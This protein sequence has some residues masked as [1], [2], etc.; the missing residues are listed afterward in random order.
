MGKEVV[1]QDASSK[2][3]EYSR[4]WNHE[5]IVD[6]LTINSGSDSIQGIMFDPPQLENV[7]WCGSSFEKMN[8]LRILIVRNADFSVAPK[9]LPNN[10]RM[11]EWNR[12]L[13]EYLPQGFYPKIMVVLKLKNSQ[14]ISSIPLQNLE[15]L[16]HMDFSNCR[17]VTQVPDLSSAPNITTLALQGCTGLINVH[18]SVGIHP[19]LRDLSFF[20]CTNLTIFPRGIKMTSLERLHLSGC[21]S[22]QH[23]PNILEE[24]VNLWFINA[25]CTSI[26]EIPHSICYLPRLKHLSLSFCYDLISLPESIS[27]LDRLASLDLVDCKKLRQFSAPPNLAKLWMDGCESLT[28]HSLNSI[29]SQ[30]LKAVEPFELYMPR[31]HIPNWFHHRSD[32]GSLSPMEKCVRNSTFAPIFEI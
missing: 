9:S 15:N 22:L 26:K 16:T 1:K 18:D 24:M 8:N 28:L 10:L 27:Q 2:L 30:A 11:L 20:G 4:L 5:D 17:L 19:K 32:I 29:L 23:F 13:S 21:R 3:G 7:E 31:F 6:V 12:Y 25:D 14:F